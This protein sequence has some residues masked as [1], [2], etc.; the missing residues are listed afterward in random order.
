[1]KGNEGV[2][3]GRKLLSRANSNQ[4]IVCVESLTTGIYLKAMKRRIR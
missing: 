4:E 2:L 3:I 1:M